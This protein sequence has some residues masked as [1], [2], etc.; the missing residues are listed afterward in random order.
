MKNLEIDIHWPSCKVQKAVFTNYTKDKNQIEP[1]PF[2][3]CR[4]CLIDTLF[5]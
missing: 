2:F 5:N 1:T 4:M 3:D